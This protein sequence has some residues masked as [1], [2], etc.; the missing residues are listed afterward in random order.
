MYLFLCMFLTILGHFCFYSLSDS[1]YLLDCRNKNASKS[2][3]TGRMN[4][5]AEKKCIKILLVQLNCIP[6]HSQ[7]ESG[8]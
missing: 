6:L 7:N 4:F 5:L 8:V 3:Y 1:C 2:V